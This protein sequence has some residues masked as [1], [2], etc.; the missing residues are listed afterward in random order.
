MTDMPSSQPPGWYYAQGDPPGTHRYWDGSQWQGGPQPV[1]GAGSVAATA[2]RTAGAGSR[3]LGWLVDA[4]ILLIPVAVVG[5]IVGGTNQDLAA[6]SVRGWLSS[7]L[8]TAI[9]FGYHYYFVTKDGA[10]PGKKVAN[11]K[12]VSADG[13]AVTNEQVMKRFGIGFLG[14]IPLVGGLIQLGIGLVSLVFLFAD[15]ESRTVW[16]RFAGTKVVES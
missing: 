5:G 15:A 16:D 6:F 13:S 11:A 4:L 8:T 1:S 7:L 2:N 3:L 9:W 12:I 14:L 10:T